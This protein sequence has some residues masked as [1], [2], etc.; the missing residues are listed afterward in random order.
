MSTSILLRGGVI[1]DPLLMLTRNGDL[2]IE[3]GYVL[4]V[5]DILPE[6]PGDIVYDV[7]NKLVM[8]GLVDMHVHVAK[9]PDG[10]FMLVRTG[11]TT[12]L[13]MMGRPD[14]IIAGA[15]Q[16]GAGL[17]LGFLYP[18]IPGDTLSGA[19]PSS[20][21]LRDAIDFALKNG[22][23]GVKVLGGHYPLTRKATAAAIELAHE[24]RCWIAVHAG[25]V[26]TPGDIRGFEELIRLAG[27]FPVHLAHIN[28]Y[29]RGLQE[30]PLIEAKRA[31]D[32]L[33]AAPACCSES[34]LALLNGC[35]GNL[36]NGRP[37][38]KVAS[39]CLLQGGYSNDEAGMLAA[40]SEGWGRVNYHDAMRR[41][42]V[43]VEPEVGLKLYREAG[44]EV[45]ISFN[46][47]SP[48]A[49]IP[50]ALAKRDNGKFVIDAL[51]TDGGEMPRNVTLRQGLCLVK[52]GALSLPELARKASLNPA[53]LLGLN[54]KGFIAVGAD[55]DIVVVDADSAQVELVIAGGKTILRNGNPDG[56]DSSFI[57][58]REGESFFYNNN[59]SCHSVAPSWLGR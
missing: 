52:F 38:S 59:L 54:N 26:E 43:L 15:R 50:L 23:L 57:S 53:R 20:R 4:D 36:V 22:A 1:V 49:A 34:Y 24:R 5:A 51:A 11:V 30:H 41:E 31:L 3:N 13:D 18:L 45:R 32:A 19:N 55:A 21:E 42:V 25:S 9:V 8:P 37:S 12:A 10:R 14:K 27:K 28:S 6:K 33:L 40:I 17:N 35:N 46:V 7:S 39:R 16:A 48:V 2:R 47:N 58:L 29:C 56:K 44:S